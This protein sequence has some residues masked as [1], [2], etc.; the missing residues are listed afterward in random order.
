MR[1][2]RFFRYVWRVNGIAVLLILAAVIITVS[3][4]FVSDQIRKTGPDN[5]PIAQPVAAEGAPKLQLRPPRPVTG[6]RMLRA[7]LVRTRPQSSY[8]S[9]SESSETHNILFIDPVT[10]ASRWLLKTHKNVV[11]YTD[12]I[13]AFADDRR[14]ERPLLA[15]VAL[16]KTAAEGDDDVATGELL[17]FDPSGAQVVPIASKVRRV[18]ATLA[19]S[20]AEFV[21]VFERDGKYHV[22]RF[23]SAT[24]RKVGEAEVSI[25]ALL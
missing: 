4:S 25:P 22:A 3:V 21:V 8:G 20:S 9:G 5:G 13:S 24:R 19:V 18:Y 12:D 14:G 6:T 7:E 23:D 15:T 17:M 10:G 2:T 11:A 16:V 1:A